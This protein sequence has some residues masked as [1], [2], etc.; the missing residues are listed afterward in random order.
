MKVG[1]VVHGQH[2]SLQ[3]LK[4]KYRSGLRRIYCGVKLGRSELKPNN[5]LSAGARYPGWH[6]D[7]FGTSRTLFGL[8]QLEGV[9]ETSA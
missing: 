6:C 8:F 7:M 5:C 3:R 9:G 2:T 4:V 1:A